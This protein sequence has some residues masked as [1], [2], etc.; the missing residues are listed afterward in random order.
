MI[1]FPFFFKEF[2][3]YFYFLHFPDQWIDEPS[4]EIK[5]TVCESIKEAT[6][7]YAK[8]PTDIEWDFS[9]ITL[10][11]GEKAHHGEFS[12]LWEW[13]NSTINLFPCEWKGFNEQKVWF[14]FTMAIANSL[15][16]YILFINLQTLE[17][18][19][20]RRV[21]VAMEFLNLEA[22]SDGYPEFKMMISNY[23]PRRCK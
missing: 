1:T 14:Y 6:M 3:Y 10:R 16:C 9:H 7:V 17:D 13:K 20:L 19:L 4:K 23:K 12:A 2:V 5:E 21:G 11:F 22:L 15:K 18:P 8:N